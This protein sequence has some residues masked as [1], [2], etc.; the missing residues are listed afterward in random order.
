[1]KMFLLLFLLKLLLFADSVV[2]VGGIIAT[3]LV[4]VVAALVPAIAVSPVAF[5]IVVATAEVLL[6]PLLLL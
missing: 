4:D 1:M 3:T 5:V 6:L 2:A